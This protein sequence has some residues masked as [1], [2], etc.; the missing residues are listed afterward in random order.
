MALGKG[1]LDWEDW[2]MKM[3]CIFW[4]FL[5]RL[6]V[7]NKTD[8][9]RATITVR[10][11][12]A[13]ATQACGPALQRAKYLVIECVV[14]LVLRSSLLYQDRTPYLCFLITTISTVRVD[15]NRNFTCQSYHAPGTLGSVC[16]C[17]K[18]RVSDR[19][20]EANIE[21]TNVCRIMVPRTRLYSA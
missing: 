17:Y 8:S 2:Y 18:N 21:V 12:S 3:Q 11:M 7:V 19:F 16:C 6:K 4:I 5:C 14:A 9:L 1:I 13:P 10:R 20:C 15:T